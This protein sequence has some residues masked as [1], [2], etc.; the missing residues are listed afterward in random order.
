MLRDLDKQAYTEYEVINVAAS[1]PTPASSL[2]MTPA[3][4]TIN[5]F[6]FSLK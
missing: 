2:S 4:E 3:A 5:I 6:I 1:Q